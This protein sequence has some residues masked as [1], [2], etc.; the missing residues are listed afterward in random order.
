MNRSRR[1]NRFGLASGLRQFFGKGKRGTPEREAERLTR[2]AGAAPEQ[3][4][5]ALETRQLL[6]TLT[7]DPQTV[8]PLTGLGQAS[9]TFGYVIPYLASPQPITVVAGQTLDEDFNENDP[10]APVSNVPSGWV[11]NGTGNLR[12]DHNLTQLQL[13]QIQAGENQLTAVIGPG[14]AIALGPV[15]GQVAPASNNRDSIIS[16]SMDILGGLNASDVTAEFLDAD[17]VVI[18]SVTGA[19]GCSGPSG[20]RADPAL[21]LHDHA[22]WRLLQPD[23]V[24]GIGER[25]QRFV[26]DRQHPDEPAW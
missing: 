20:K 7:I 5:E 8:N 14:E 23:P 15:G 21:H 6:F 13:T 3:A 26:F 11:F 16:M 22:G 17:G 19:A 2:A 24:R 4:F 18:D 10:G 9:A 1:T 25:S 12:V